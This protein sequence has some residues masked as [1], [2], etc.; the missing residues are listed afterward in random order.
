MHI[1][2]Q[3]MEIEKIYC[4]LLM[5]NN[6]SIAICSANQGEGVT[7][8]ALALA[9][10]NLL[11]GKSTLVVDFNL[12]RPSFSKLLPTD[13][14]RLISHESLESP[15]LVTTDEQQTVALIGVTSPKRRD[16]I[17]KL[18]QPGMLE[19]CIEE[20]KT[21]YDTIIFDT[22]PINRINAN[23][24]PAE[25]V[26]AACDASLLVVLAGHTTE[27]MITSAVYK[28]NA[29]GAQLQGCIYND[30]DNPTLQ[31][32]LL[33]EVSRLEPKLNWLT[34]SIKNFINNSRLLTLEI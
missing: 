30:R 19:Q 5:G 17:L 4:N 29:A 27:A 33:R 20:W 28:L 13:T 21:S 11:A 7:S 9:Q 34:R 1:P 14:N 32:E 31:K 25:R 16:L 12:Y 26:A 3:N 23:N 8:I 6:N 15:Q 10:R 18:R 24:I 2:P 22:S